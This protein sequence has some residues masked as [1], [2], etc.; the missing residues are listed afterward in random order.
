MARLIISGGFAGAGKK[1][2]WDYLNE[3][4]FPEAVRIDATQSQE[5]IFTEV[6]AYLTTPR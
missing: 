2:E 3:N 1:W 5:V 6:I 4:D